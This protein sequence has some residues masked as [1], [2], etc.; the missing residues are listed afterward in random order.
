MSKVFA[1]LGM[2]LDGFIAGLN[3]GEK[4]P[5]GDGGLKI[6]EWMFR[7][8]SFREHLGMEGGE[9]NNIDNEII[10]KT[11]NRIGANI[12]G[13]RMFVE[14]EANWPEEA[15]FNCPVYVLTHQKRKPWERPGGTTFFFTD[16]DVQTVLLKAK[17]V[18]GEK[19]VRISGGAKTIQQYLNEGLVEEFIVHLAPIFLGSGARLFEHLD[20]TKFSFEIKN[21]I[22]SKAITHLYYN[23]KNN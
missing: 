23:V 6:H 21:V 10:E 8:K 18:A 15:P 17:K 22:H 9:T 3:G 1:D 7:Q 2:S 20:K 19:D 14:G 4:N 5:L 11:F 13:K 16:E 12:M